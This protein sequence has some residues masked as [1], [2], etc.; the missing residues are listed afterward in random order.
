MKKHFFLISQV[1]YPDEVSTAGLF[2]NLC[3]EIAKKEVNVDVWCAQ[4][5]YN[6]KKDKNQNKFIKESI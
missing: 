1:F 6:T 2:T 5:S 3:E 4:P